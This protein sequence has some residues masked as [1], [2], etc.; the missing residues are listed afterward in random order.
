MA[1]QLHRILENF[2]WRLETLTPTTGKTKFKVVDPI[3]DDI[4]DH[5]GSFRRF[6][7]E[8]ESSQEDLTM[9]DGYSRRAEHSIRLTVFYPA[10]KARSHKDLRSIILQ[11]RHDIIKRLRDTQ[12]YN[13]FN[14]DNSSTDLGL[15]YRQRLDD[16]LTTGEHLWVFEMT[17]ECTIEEI[18]H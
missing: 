7:V 17:F 11:D 12:Y 9:T 15:E 14:A 6:Y 1:T 13:G 2:E 5:S 8:W 16:E 10:S 3:N 18:E 4:G